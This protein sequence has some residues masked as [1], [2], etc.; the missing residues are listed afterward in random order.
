MQSNNRAILAAAGS[1]K[2]ETIIRAVVESDPV[3]RILITT[4]TNENLAQITRRITE[5]LGT[6]PPNVTIM[7]WFPFLL[8]D[9]VKP[10]QNYVTSTNRVKSIEF[11]NR[12]DQY[13]KR[14]RVDYYIDPASNLY[15]DNVADFACV[16][17]EKSGNKVVS[18]LENLYD[19]IYID[20][21]QDLVGY[22]LDLLDLLFSS[23]IA[24]TVVGDPRQSTYTTSK[25]RKNK[26]YQ[27]LKLFD[28]YVEREKEGALTI[29]WRNES[30]R[31]HQA[32]CDFADALYPTLP[33]TTSRN[34]EETG[35]D[36]VF[37]IQSSELDAYMSTYRPIAMRY[38]K[39]TKTGGYPAVNFGASKGS[40]Y[41]R[42]VIFPT[43][44]MKKY[45]KTGNLDDAGDVSKFYVAV[46]RARS[47][48]AFV[49]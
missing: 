48:V 34:T 18:R 39:T 42:V 22:D 5:A 17:N 37:F 1:H 10:Y 32:I 45:F 38:S 30:F 11:T 41:N 8:R 2:T 31:C 49:L 46:T 7:G 33:P 35:H 20:E 24:V 16:I 43:N 36:G 19:Q 21:I 40:T 15:S 9:C 44:P 29:E 26:A 13:V 12:P 28:W 23:D 27:R 47:S 6:V 14:S 25:T 3:T 4:Y